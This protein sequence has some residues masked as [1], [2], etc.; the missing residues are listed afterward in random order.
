MT[1]DRQTVKLP[2]VKGSFPVVVDIESHPAIADIATW[3]K[4]LKQHLEEAC[5]RSYK[6]KV[7]AIGPESLPRIR[8]AS[9]VWKH[10]QIQQISIDPTIPDALVVYVIPAWDESEHMEWCI[11]NGRLVYVGQFLSYPPD[12]YSDISNGNYA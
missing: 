10:L 5:F 6:A 2:F 3:S 11:D 8:Q 12:G 4:D 1:D 9:H 7:E